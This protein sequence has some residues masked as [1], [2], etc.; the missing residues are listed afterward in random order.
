[1]QGVV[2]K[3][4]ESKI[5][6]MMVA[7]LVIGGATAVTMLPLEDKVGWYAWDPAVGDVDHQSISATPKIIDAIE[8]MYKTAYGKL[9][10][11]LEAP[12]GAWDNPLV[13]RLDSGIRINGS[14]GTSGGAVTPVPVTF[15]DD[16]I[17]NMK[18]IS[19]GAGFTDSFVEMFRGRDG[20]VW[21]TVVAAGNSTWSSYPKNGMKGST[22]GSE[23]SI[24]FD[25]LN[26]AFGSGNLSKEHTYCLI[27]WG[28][29][30]QTVHNSIMTGISSMTDVR[31]SVLYIDY[32]SLINSDSF[33]NILYTVDALGLLIGIDT[34]DN[35]ALSDFQDRLYSMNK[36]LETD[37][38]AGTLK[39]YME[40]PSGNSPGKGTL[41][42]LC[43]DTLM[44][45]NI[46]TTAGSSTKLSDEIVVM[47][48]PDVIFFDVTDKRTI[49]QKMRIVA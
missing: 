2:K 28:Y 30:G 43:F 39:V 9:P 31:M 25:A 32:Y 44:L 27:V 8:Q 46:N 1:M 21:D 41:A 48:S 42:H 29:V 22:L 38:S 35:R 13:D 12:K 20:S 45:D 6:A 17:R 49:Y 4:I 10:T 5:A 3:M 7:A 37:P 14:L 15:T 34:D 26:A 24:S 16:D 33:D 18:V 47:S 36:A 11:K 23:W 19:Y 40:L